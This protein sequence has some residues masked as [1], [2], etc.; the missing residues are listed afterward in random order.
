MNALVKVIDLQGKVHSTLTWNG[1]NISLDLT[2]FTS[3]IYLIQ[4][5]ENGSTRIDRVVKN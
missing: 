1:K 2:K 3:G 4:T 5:V